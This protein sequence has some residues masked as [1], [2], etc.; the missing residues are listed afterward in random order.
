[1]MSALN[2]LR[3]ALGGFMKAAEVLYVVE[4]VKPVS[5]ILC[6]EE[7]AREI[8]E[9]L[10]HHHLAVEKAD[11]K[12]LLKSSPSTSYID[13]SIAAELGDMRKGHS[14]LYISKEPTLAKLA[15]QCE[16]KQQHLE[17]GRLLGYPE[18]CCLFFW[19]HFS[20]ART[21]LTLNVLEHSE[22]W[23]FP[24]W[25][26]IAARHLDSALLSHFPHSFQCPHSIALGKKY[27]EVAQKHFPQHEKII[28]V[29]KSAVVYTEKEGIVFLK[30]PVRE[31]DVITY[32]AAVS[33]MQSKLHYL[34]DEEKKI[35]VLG[36]HTFKAGSHTIEGTDK[37][38]MLFS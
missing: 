22:G 23:E 12:L 19:S 1:M 7:N 38:V 6:H 25:T 33:T 34:L 32:D 2:E 3:K 26:N 17:L 20:P 8:E 27:L 5:R 4:G 31:K 24:Y 30:N 37:G 15:K 35:T 11:M 10:R 13:A 14:I 28:D 21:D 36:K 16:I 18:C 29:L 9:L